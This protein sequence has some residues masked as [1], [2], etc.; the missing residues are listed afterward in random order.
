MTR[1]SKW[2][3]RKALLV[4][5]Q[6]IQRIAHFKVTIISL[7]AD[8]IKTFAFGLQSFLIMDPF[9]SQCIGIY[10]SQLVF[11]SAI[12]FEMNRGSVNVGDI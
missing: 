4:S 9:E 6:I 8:E 12:C 2:I 5:D 10:E 1:K 7:G 3:S 11:S